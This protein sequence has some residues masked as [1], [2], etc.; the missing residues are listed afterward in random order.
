MHKLRK[1]V[2]MTVVIGTNLGGKYAYSWL[3]DARR[4]T[5]CSAL[6]TIIISSLYLYILYYKSVHTV[7]SIVDTSTV[8]ALIDS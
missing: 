3:T 8:P 2:E 1:V 6:L 4:H 5:H 7:T